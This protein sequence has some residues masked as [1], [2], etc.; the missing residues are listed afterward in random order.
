MAEFTIFRPSDLKVPQKTPRSRVEVQGRAS[1]GLTAFW[2]KSKIWKNTLSRWMRST[3]MLMIIR[4]CNSTRNTK[5]AWKRT[6]IKSRKTT[7]R[8]WNSRKKNMKRP[9]TL[10]LY[11]F[12]H[13]ETTNLCSLDSTKEKVSQ[14]KLP[15]AWSWLTQPDLWEVWSARPS[16]PFK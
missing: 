10:P 14:E 3:N 9:P 11:Y 1:L 6:S 15:K 8:T 5:E 7:P 4:A 16:R 2:Y 13:M 12:L